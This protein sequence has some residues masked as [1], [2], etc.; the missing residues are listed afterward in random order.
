[1]SEPARVPLNAD[2]AREIDGCVY[3]TPA[4]IGYD[5]IQVVGH[6]K[7]RFRVRDVPVLLEKGFSFP[8]CPMP[9]VRCRVDWHWIDAHPPSRE[10][11]YLCDLAVTRWG[12][13]VYTLEWAPYDEAEHKVYWPAS[14]GDPDLFPPD[15]GIVPPTWEEKLAATKCTISE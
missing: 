4:E 8:G 2:H 9:H 6:T 5:A 1:M 12:P 15:T 14:R 11:I 10:E 13:E 7:Y 3:L